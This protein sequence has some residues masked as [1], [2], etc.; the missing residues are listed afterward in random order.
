MISIDQFVNAIEDDAK[1]QTT[2]F[3]AAIERD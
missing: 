3:G 2:E 1:N